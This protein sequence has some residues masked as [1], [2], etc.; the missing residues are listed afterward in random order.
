MRKLN[1]FSVFA[2]IAIIIFSI[3][4][5]I[6]SQVPDRHTKIVEEIQK[7]ID[8]AKRAEY[9]PAQELLEGVLTQYPENAAAYNN[10]ASIDILEGKYGSAIWKCWNALLHDKEDTNIYL[11]LGIAY[12]LQMN[13][14]QQDD[15]VSGKKSEVAR[16]D[17]RLLSESAFDK[18]FEN[19]KSAAEACHI[20]GIPSVE[21]PEYSWVQKLL[22]ESADREHKPGGLKA[23]GNRSRSEWKIPVYWKRN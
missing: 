21:S 8:Y 10:L 18:A 3:P 16:Q 23:G 12:Y 6:E 14:T 20:L 11:N 7:G 5:Q 4:G 1:F 15:Y 22:R 17:W 19:L 9:K 13:I 2:I